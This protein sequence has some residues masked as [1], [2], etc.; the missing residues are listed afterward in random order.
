MSDLITATL[1]KYPKLSKVRKADACRWALQDAG[2]SPAERESML[3]AANVI[4]ILGQDW[5]AM[6][7]EFTPRP[8][9]AR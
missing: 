9:G 2:V 4:G 6:S 1:K 3:V 8:K 5:G 7:E